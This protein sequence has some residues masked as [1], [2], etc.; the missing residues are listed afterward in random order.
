MQQHTT[1]ARMKNWSLC[2]VE[3]DYYLKLV[4]SLSSPKWQSSHQN[5]DECTLDKTD[6]AIQVAK[7]LGWLAYSLLDCLEFVRLV[8]TNF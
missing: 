5:K 2:K 3:V 1:D 7:L 6:V 4:I 8:I